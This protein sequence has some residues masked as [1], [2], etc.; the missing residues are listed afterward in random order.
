MPS[1]TA[2]C[3]CGRTF[4]YISTISAR[5]E[6]TECD[7]GGLAK[8][9]V[10]AELA[11]GKERHKWITENERFSVSAGVPVPQIEQFKKLYPGSIYDS[12]GRL[13]IK[14]RKHKLYEMKRRGM[15]EM[16][17]RKE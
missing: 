15:V 16:D 5:N 7:C 8:R 1:Y 17:N 13:L 9:D 14:N 12:K 4:S 2:T 10:E 11:P 3:K 6:P